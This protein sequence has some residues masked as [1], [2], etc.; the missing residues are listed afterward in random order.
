MATKKL[1][2]INAT[3]I[4]D[5]NFDKVSEVTAE[6]KVLRERLVDCSQEDKMHIMC[7]LNALAKGLTTLVLQQ[8]NCTDAEVKA[9]M[10]SSCPDNVHYEVDING[11]PYVYGKHIDTKVVLNKAYL[12]S[13]GYKDNVSLA[14]D[15]LSKGMTLPAEFE[16]EQKEICS[17]LPDK[18][19]GSPFG[20]EESTVVITVDNNT[21]KNKINK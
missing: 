14:R 10:D 8:C 19:P 7:K 6:I 12:N 15:Y 11:T 20:Q 16:F 18:V 5:Y 1:S 13:L 21:Y 17:F 9:I 3:K 4:G 2:V